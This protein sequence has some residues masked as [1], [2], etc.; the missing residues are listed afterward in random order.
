MTLEIAKQDC[1]LDAIRCAAY[2]RYSSDVQ[3]PT[4]IDDQ[5]RNCTEFAE[6]HSWS[7][8]AE[9]IRSDKGKSGETLVTRTGLLSLIED[10]KKKPRPFDCV[11]IDDTSRLGRNLS[12]VL[13]VSEILVFNDVFLYFVTQEIDSRDKHYQKLLIDNGYQD[14]NAMDALRARVHRG[15]K[16]VALK[17]Y[18]T[19]GTRYGYQRVL[20]ED[21]TRKDEHGRPAIHHSEL[22]VDPEE[23]EVVKRVYE[24]RVKGAL[25]TE[26]ARE[27]NA[28][29]I[30]GPAGATWTYTGVRSILR[31]E[32][33]HG[34]KKWNATKN[35][36]NPDTGKIYPKNRPESEWVIVKRPELIIV[37]EEL[38][39]A[40][41]EIDRK[42]A[43]PGRRQQLGGLHRTHASRTYLFSGIIKCGSCL[44]PMNIIRND[45]IGAWYGCRGHFYGKL[46]SN[47]LKI[48][49]DNL[50]EQLIDAMIA[51][52]RCDA[53]DDVMARSQEQIQNE[54]NKA[55][56]VVGHTNCEKKLPELMRKQ[57]NLARA[58][59]SY[60]DSEALIAE[61][62]AIELE[63][64]KAKDQ[65][66]STTDVASRV[67]FDD[68]KSF[69]HQKA[70]NLK[71]VLLGDRVVAKRVLNHLVHELLLT[72][73][74][75]P[76]GP[77]YIVQGDINLFGADS[78][79]MHSVSAEHSAKHYA[80]PLT[81]TGLQL[82]PRSAVRVAA[83]SNVGGDAP[84]VAP[85]TQTL[86]LDA[87]SV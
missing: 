85:P 57:Q 30:A 43:K 9:Y 34:I 28:D 21:P 33:Y 38:W 4:S 35:K 72:P 36:K 61:L 14:Q 74:N 40:A 84:I 68:F 56:G 67:S 41:Q 25:L 50:E 54:L 71:S 31:N 49:C 16:G 37:S 27:L 29:G 79:V 59:A 52:L 81:L 42:T 82:D 8:L 64:Q 60:E 47:N 18:H 86:S 10:A 2:L 26:I 24:T 32:L 17:G 78:G 55:A 46:C 11:L 75:T 1:G 65:Q 7:I 6:Q 19:G 66:A 20:I 39:E 44:D 69:V 13:K 80:F 58:I 51:N 48:K 45:Y 83:S 53:L 87:A 5:L 63:I 15:M 73:K 70:D 23:S 76:D 3:S 12:D 62:R 77:V 22:R